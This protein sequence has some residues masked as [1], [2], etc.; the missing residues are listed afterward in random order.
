MAHS[1]GYDCV[2]CRERQSADLFFS[3]D[4]DTCP[5]EDLMKG[6]A[7]AWE[8]FNDYLLFREKALDM[9]W[10]RERSRDERGILVE[11]LRLILRKMDEI[12]PGFLH[13]IG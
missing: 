12:C 9:D 8:L 11:K 2:R 7:D 6:N 1:Y 3:K 4:C 5:H 13:G 10:F